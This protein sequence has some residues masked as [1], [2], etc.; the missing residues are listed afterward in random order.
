MRIAQ[1]T[2]SHIVAPGQ[3]WKGRVD[4][5]EGLAR[6]VARLNEIAPD[7]VVHTG[8]VV[9]GGGEAQYGLA[10][11]ILSDLKP[12]L[13]LLPGNHDLRARMRAAFPGKVPA[14]GEFLNFS[15][16]SAGLQILGLD[17]IEEGQ[18]AGR[19][20]AARAAWL[21]DRLARGRPTLVFAHHPPCPMGLDFMDVFVFRGSDL[22]AEA[23]QGRG[24][25]RIA[26]GHVHAAVERHWA[27]TLVAA[28]P[29]TG[30]QIPPLQ[31]PS[32]PGFTLE[33]AAIRIHDWSPALGLTA[34]LVP[35][36]PGPFHPFEADRNADFSA[37]PHAD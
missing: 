17:T 28:C 25:L 26:T 37:T 16:E 36:E 1:I 35:V 19:F 21:R 12:P 15:E 7:L 8:D 4:M 10:A 13:R 33:P 31:D 20:C 29:A 34:K 5:A 27:G 23:V 9:D 14:A 22:A 18:T 30:V 24:V 2:D 11:E 3:L 6:A 32:W